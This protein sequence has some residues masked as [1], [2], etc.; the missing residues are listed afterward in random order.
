MIRTGTE[1]ANVKSDASDRGGLEAE[2]ATTGAVETSESAVG[3]DRRRSTI[4]DAPLAYTFDP[5]EETPAQAI[6]DAVAAADGCDPLSL[7]PLFD[8]ID[9]DA[10]NGL[11]AQPRSGPERRSW[12]LSFEYGG[13]LVTVDADRRIVLEP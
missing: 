3:P 9:P 1:D 8:A 5:T 6:I 10:L 4:E 7:P 12:A 11:V 2:S 13:W